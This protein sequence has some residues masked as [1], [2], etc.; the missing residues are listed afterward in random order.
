MAKMS[1]VLIQAY[2]K[3]VL[4]GI[5]TLDEKDVTDECKLVPT[6][7]QEAVIKWI[8]EYTETRLRDMI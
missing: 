2:G 7:Y 1:K 4:L 5:R 3:S 8:T 6:V